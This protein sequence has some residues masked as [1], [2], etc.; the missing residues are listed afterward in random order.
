MLEYHHKIKL[1][2]PL[3]EPYDAETQWIKA[4]MIYTVSFERLTL[5]FVGK[6][7]GG[8]RTYDVR[9]ISDVDLQLIQQC[10]LKALGLDT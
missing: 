2:P 6:D 1:S 4:D 3:P 10:A 8:K 9:E 5:P 7:Q